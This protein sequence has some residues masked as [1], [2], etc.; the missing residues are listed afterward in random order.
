[1]FTAHRFGFT[2]MHY[3]NTP[4][5]TPDKPGRYELVSAQL[6]P[7]NRT[8]LTVVPSPIGKHLVAR[9]LGRPVHDLPG[10]WKR[11]DSDLTPA[12]DG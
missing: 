9:E 8:E 2:F 10:W 4:I 3:P 1:M 12:A 11:L 5:N 7:G 6:P